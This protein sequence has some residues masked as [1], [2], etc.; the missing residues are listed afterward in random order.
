MGEKTGFG[1]SPLNLEVIK[2]C[3]Y[4][5]WVPQWTEANFLPLKRLLGLFRSCWENPYTFKLYAFD[6]TDQENSPNLDIVRLKIG[7]PILNMSV[8][9]GNCQ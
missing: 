3:W 8:P 9:V 1:C 5:G 6:G 7:F 2:L 4:S